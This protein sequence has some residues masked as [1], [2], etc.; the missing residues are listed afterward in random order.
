M[1]TEAWHS[2]S[3]PQTIGKYIFIL[4]HA[5]RPNEKHFPI[6]SPFL[7]TQYNNQTNS[8]IKRDLPVS[9]S[10]I[11]ILLVISQ[12][13][14]SHMRS[15]CVLRWSV[16]NV[17]GCRNEERRVTGGKGLVPRH[18]DT[19][20]LGM[21]LLRSWLMTSRIPIKLQL[22]GKSCLILEFYYVISH[23]TME[24][25]EISKSCDREEPHSN[26]WMNKQN[27]ICFSNPTTL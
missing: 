4:P 14:R 1:L 11:G 25:H 10:F 3:W 20:Y 21:W 13:R 7:C 6:N 8:K 27:C 17:N 18:R 12:E 2:A 16:F 24:S 26:T 9:W 23:V 15:M 5:I 19:E 22:T